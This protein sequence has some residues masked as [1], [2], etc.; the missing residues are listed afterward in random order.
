M[1]GEKDS[2]GNAEDV[3]VSAYGKMGGDQAAKDAKAAWDAGA[4]GHWLD[5]LKLS[6]R[7]DHDVISHVLGHDG[8]PALKTSTPQSAQPKKSTIKR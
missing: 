7:T 3:L 4:A 2:N 8:Q 5:S 1:V 6:L